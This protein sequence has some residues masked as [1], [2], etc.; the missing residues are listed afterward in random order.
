MTRWFTSDHHFG[1]ANIIEFVP[2]PFR[3]VTHMNEM[4]VKYWNDNVGADDDVYVI[5]DFAMGQIDHTIHYAERLVGNKFLVPGNHDRCWKGHKN[6]ERWVPVYESVGF[7]VL[8]ST[9]VINVGDT[10]VLLC[11][12]PYFGDNPGKPDRYTGNRPTD[13]GGW[14]IHGHTHSVRSTVGRM[15]HVGV[16]AWD[17]HPVPET[18]VQSIIEERT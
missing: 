13:E 4:L 11:H 18:W 5:G 14:M 1:H 10:P 8:D 16:D 2:R 3:D 6:W 7:T 12:F 9:H 15:I 17:Y